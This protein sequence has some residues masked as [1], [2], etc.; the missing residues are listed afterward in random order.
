VKGIKR[1]AVASGTSVD[2]GNGRFGNSAI[3][4]ERHRGEFGKTKDTKYT[5]GIEFEKA[6][7]VEMAAATMNK[8]ST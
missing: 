7:F 4:V 5:L 3:R 1:F 8:V 2:V 6:R